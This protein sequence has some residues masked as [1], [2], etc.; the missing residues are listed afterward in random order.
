[1]SIWVEINQQNE[2]KK[3]TKTIPTYNTVTHRTLED[4]KKTLKASRGGEKNQVTK[5]QLLKWYGFK[6]DNQQ[7]PTV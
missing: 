2:L 3:K 7:G 4:I 5:A 6:M 1:M